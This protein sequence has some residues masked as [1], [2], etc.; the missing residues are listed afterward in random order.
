MKSGLVIVLPTVINDFPGMKNIA[1]PVLTQ[2]FIPKAT[3]ETL[4]KSVL[5][6]LIR[7]DYAQLNTM[8]RGSLIQRA[9]VKFRAL[10]GSYRRR[11]STK[12]R[13]AVQNTRDLNA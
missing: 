2:A 1:E 8:F 7:L 5:S 11:I 13:N 3:V 12:Q 6:W 10:N 9:T 4:N